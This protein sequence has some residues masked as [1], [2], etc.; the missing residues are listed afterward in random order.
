MTFGLGRRY[1]VFVAHSKDSMPFSAELAERLKA[2]GLRVFFDDRELPHGGDFDTAIR[3][4]VTQCGA[5]LFVSSPRSVMEG[6]YALN[7]LTWA[8]RAGRALFG[9]CDGRHDRVVPPPAVAARTL[10]RSDGDRIAEA[11]GTMLDA[12]ARQRSR[13]VVAFGI[14]G[15]VVFGLLAGIYVLST[16]DSGANGKSTRKEQVGPP[17]SASRSALAGAVLE[18][19]AAGMIRIEGS[20]LF[21]GIGP[22]QRD[23]FFAWCARNEPDR[24]NCEQ[25]LGRMEPRTADIQTFDIDRTEVS[26][27]RVAAWLVDQIRARAAAVS[28]T[29]VHRSSDGALLWD[30]ACHDLGA[31]HT[32]KGSI[33]L[34]DAKGDADAPAICVSAPAAAWYCESHATRLPLDEEWELAAGGASKRWLPWDPTGDVT[35]ACTDAVF[36]RRKGGRC[37]NFPEKQEQSVAFGKDRTPEGALNLGG[38]VSEWVERRAGGNLSFLARGGNWSGLAIDLHPAKVMAIDP[39]KATYLTVGFRCARTPR[40]TGGN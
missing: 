28:G 38:N 23:A 30:P 29:T 36:G 17:P 34:L 26:A 19:P 20:K 3:K 6:S 4:A 39:S 21:I 11:V 24:R 32:A 18:A 15:V 40:R 8:V 37:A 31:Y 22:E 12:R 9:I 33:E 13:V 7:E 25:M 16:R 2:A 27:K 1:D 14:V 10:I 35:V 5:F